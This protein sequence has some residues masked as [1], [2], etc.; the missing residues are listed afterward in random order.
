MYLY[1]CIDSNANVYGSI[2]HRS[3]KQSW[4]YVYAIAGWVLLRE[5]VGVRGVSE[6]D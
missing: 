4:S 3:Q 5:I 6:Y 1:L 2:N